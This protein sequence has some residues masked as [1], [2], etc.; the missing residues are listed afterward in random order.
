VSGEPEPP[1]KGKE[2]SNLIILISE[3]YNFQVIS[4]VLMFDIIRTLLDGALTEIDV[5]LLL[6]ILRS[7]FWSRR[8]LNLALTYFLCLGCG[9]QLRQDDPLALKDIVQIV[10]EKVAGQ[11]EST[12]SRTRFMVETLLN[13]KN[14]KIKKVAAAQ[15][16]GDSSMERMK[17]FLSGLSKSRT[18]MFPARHS[19]PLWI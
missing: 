3:L 19:L 1:E 14:N 4:C 8:R 10:Q 11:K 2:C 16:Q 6:K 12:S 13:L 5:E 7:Q 18:S 9:E 17:K 15:S